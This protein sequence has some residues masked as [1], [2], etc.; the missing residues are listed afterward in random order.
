MALKMRVEKDVCQG[1]MHIM[2]ES[3]SCLCNKTTVLKAVSGLSVK[4]NRQFFKAGWD[5]L[6]YFAKLNFQ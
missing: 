3:R 2:V 4:P 1:Y 6:M 5:G